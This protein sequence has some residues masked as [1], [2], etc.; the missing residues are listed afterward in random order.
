MRQILDEIE[1]K[2]LKIIAESDKAIGTW[3][4]ASKLE[5]ENIETSPATVGRILSKLE[6]LSYLEKQKYKG[7][8]ITPEGKHAIQIAQTIEVINYHKD[9]MDEIITTGIL[10]NFIMI[11][12]ARQAIERETAKLAAKYITKEELNTLWEIILR[13]EEKFKN[14]ESI[15]EEDIAFHKT[16]AKASRN[17]ILESMYN[18]VATFNQQSLVFEHL[19]KQINSPYS[20]YHRKIYNAIK[21]GDEKEAERIMAEHMENLKTD[22]LTYWNNFGNEGTQK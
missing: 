5:E 18:I 2:I 14:E 17:I 3:T 20:M 11:I 10:E 22:V 21:A 6:N 12:Q 8:V 7:R 9:K 19:R 1:V 15:A 16:I 13:Q 4:I